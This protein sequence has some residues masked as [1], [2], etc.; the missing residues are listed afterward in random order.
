MK[1]FLILALVAF[2]EL[3]SIVEDDFSLCDSVM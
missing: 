1:K 3:V 2:T